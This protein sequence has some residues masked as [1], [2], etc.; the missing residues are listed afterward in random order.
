M[1]MIILIIN[2]M[3]KNIII[4]VFVYLFIFFSKF[5]RPGSIRIAHQIETNMDEAEMDYLRITSHIF[6]NQTITLIIQNRLE[7]SIKLRIKKSPT[8]YVLYD[9]E[10]RSIATFIWKK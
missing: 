8:K 3:G 5:I 7:K 1:V 6:N 2:R 10:A 9:L 4:S